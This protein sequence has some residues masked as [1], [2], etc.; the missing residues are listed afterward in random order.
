[1]KGRTVI[2]IAH[3]LSTVE[4][5]DRI[6]VIDK[7]KL[8]E[9]GSHAQLLE[10]G[11]LYS[12]LVSRQLTLGFAT[13]PV[14]ESAGEPKNHII[15][16]PLQKSLPPAETTFGSYRSMGSFG[17]MTEAEVHISPKEGS[18]QSQSNEFGT[19]VA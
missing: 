6:L 1:M 11:G 18:P 15:K 4:R 12:Q 14:P 17:S 9:Q 2:V 3:R 8:I 16:K 7:G 5:A 19:P 10:Q 13:G